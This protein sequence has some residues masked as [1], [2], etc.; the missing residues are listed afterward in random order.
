M[1]LDRSILKT[2]SDYNSSHEVEVGLLGLL[3]GFQKI[4]DFFWTGFR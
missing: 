3:K 1:R 4:T 2:L